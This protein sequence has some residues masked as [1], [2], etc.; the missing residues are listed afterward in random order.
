MPSQAIGDLVPQV[1]AAVAATAAREKSDADRVVKK[2][3]RLL[4]DAKDASTQQA[5]EKKVFREGKLGELKRKVDVEQKKAAE[6]GQPAT[7]GQPFPKPQQVG[8]GPADQ[9]NIP[10]EQVRH[11]GG[12]EAP[13]MEPEV[14]PAP[15]IGQTVTT[16][17]EVP[18]RTSSGYQFPILRSR[19]R[20]TGT[21]QAQAIQ[22]AQEKRLAAQEGR[23]RRE[24]QREAVIRLV[25]AGVPG[26]E[27]AEIPPEQLGDWNGYPESIQ[28]KLIAKIEGDQLRALSQESEA[29]KIAQLRVEAAGDS[30]S[31]AKLGVKARQAEIKLGHLKLEVTEELANQ[32]RT[33]RLVREKGAL[34][35]ATKRMDIAEIQAKT[36]GKNAESATINA[37]AS[38][39]RAKVAEM[40]AEAAKEDRKY[41]EAHR[42]EERLLSKASAVA[43]LANAQTGLKNRVNA[44]LSDSTDMPLSFFLDGA[45][46]DPKKH[47]QYRNALVQGVSKLERLGLENAGPLEMYSHVQMPAAL[48]DMVVVAGTKQGKNWLSLPGK[49]PAFDFMPSSEVFGLLWQAGRGNTPGWSQEQIEANGRAAT[50]RLRNL[51]VIDGADKQAD[52]T[53]VIRKVGKG[54]FSRTSAM[55]VDV[56]EGREE[57]ARELNIP[58]SEAGRAHLHGPIQDKKAAEQAEKYLGQLMGEIMGVQQRTPGAPGAR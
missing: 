31:A 50:T 46:P 32:E 41:I 13:S 34:E 37:D 39:T 2:F 55:V 57:M 43:M 52:G 48:L 47:L 19:Q 10:I 6:V 26:G 11:V 40:G 20:T 12:R 5:A 25:Q 18:L 24:Y 21:S 33:D 15:P 7:L 30:A 16:E 28:R 38:A 36:A 8:R 44:G 42:D 27:I 22:A 4:E 58:F 14:G 3:Q 54:P 9:P 45:I 17:R 53:F 49:V 23:T 1:V 29:L 51:Q 35:L 56:Y